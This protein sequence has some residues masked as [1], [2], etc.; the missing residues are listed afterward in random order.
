[1]DLV[2][3]T[4]NQDLARFS[5]SADDLYAYTFGAPRASMTEP[6]YTNVHDVKDGDDLL[7]GYMFPEQWGFHNTGTY[8][9]I[10]AADLEIAT[11]AVNIEDLVDS[12]KIANVISGDSELTLDTGTRRGKEF[13]DEW[14][15]F[16]TSHGLTREYFNDVVKE[17]LSAIMRVY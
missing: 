17:P 6:G 14:L 2:T 3:K 8:E 16:I 13:M 7:L 9:E 1:M 12:S 15:E 10:H 4:I 5:V 11:Y